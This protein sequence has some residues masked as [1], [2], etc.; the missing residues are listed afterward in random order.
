[1]DRIQTM[2]V[3]VAIAEAGS[4]A[5][6]ARRL[7]LSPPSATRAVA[8]LEARLGAKLLHRTT[9]SVHVTDA[10]ARYLA[11]CRRILTELDEIERHVVGTHAT[12]RGRV[13]VSA[14][15]M[16]GRMAVAPILLDL[17]ERHAELTVNAMFVDRVVNIVE[18]GVDVAVRIA[19][20]PDSSLQAVRVGAV[21]RVVCASPEYL[22]AN[23]APATPADLAAH[24]TIDFVNAGRG[25]AWGFMAKGKAEVARHRPRLTVNVADAAIAAAKAGKGLTRVL[26]YMVAADVAAGMLTLVLEGF[27][28]APTPVHVVHKEPGLTSARVRAVVDHLVDALRGSPLLLA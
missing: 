8:A 24:A 20:L 10:G 4:F 13:T 27:A 3:F 5:G 1:M 2:S 25:D 14:S 17:L 26:S 6:A 16:F 7:G 21:R 23:G 22:A 19:E 28:L 18:E 11:D 12:P 15:V 9:R